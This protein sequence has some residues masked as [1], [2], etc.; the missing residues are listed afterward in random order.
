MTLILH[1][2]QRKFIDLELHQVEVGVPEQRRATK[3]LPKSV[4][5]ALVA[6]SEQGI[7][8]N[9]NMDA[10]ASWGSGHASRTCRRTAVRPP[11]CWT[12]TSRSR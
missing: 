9:D 11:G 7:T 8:V 5:M 12:R 6:G 4:Y 10:S 2:L 1:E 3:H